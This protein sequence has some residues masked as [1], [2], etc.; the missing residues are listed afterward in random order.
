MGKDKRWIVINERNE[1]VVDEGWEWCMIATPKLINFRDNGLDG[2]YDLQDRRVVLKPRLKSICN[3]DNS[4]FS[5][6]QDGRFHLIDINGRIV[7]KRAFVIIKQFV[8]GIAAAKDEESNL[9]GFINLAGEW[10]IR[11]S[12]WHAEQFAGGLSPVCREFGEYFYIDRHGDVVIPG[13][14]IDAQGFSEGLAHVRDKDGDHYIDS[15]GKIKFSGGD[16]WSCGGAFS[17]NRASVLSRKQLEKVFFIDKTGKMVGDNLY[18]KSGSFSENV[19]A[20]TV[21]NRWGLVDL[22]GRLVVPYQFDDIS[23][24]SCGLSAAE[25]EGKC[26]YIDSAGR[27]VIEFSY[28]LAGDF[29]PA[30]RLACVEVG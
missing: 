6:E 13:P 21:N 2:L 23:F 8:D 11:P 26:G 12:F 22:S 1:T 29:E 9:Y 14:F 27:Q 10:V 15:S 24:Q 30:N 19:A 7:C 17:C 4:V 3:I 16:D 25:L 18:G 28:S 5:M 20:V